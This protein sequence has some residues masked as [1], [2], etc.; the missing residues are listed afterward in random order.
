MTTK[1]KYCVHIRQNN[2]TTKFYLLTTPSLVCFYTS[3]S[4]VFR[5]VNTVQYFI[6]YPLLS[7]NKIMSQD[8]N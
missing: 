8:D 4:S 3:P 2:Y 5:A 7:A 1:Q 6:Y